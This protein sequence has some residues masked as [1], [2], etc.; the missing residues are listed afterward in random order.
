[1]DGGYHRGMKCIVLALLFF[2]TSLMAQPTITYNLEAA[3]MANLSV[4]TMND[5]GFNE[6]LGLFLAGPNA[7]DLAS[8]LPVVTVLR[9]SGTHKI[10]YLNVRYVYTFKD[11]STHA[12]YSEHARNPVM[13]DQFEPGQEIV[14]YPGVGV[15][16]HHVTGAN[17]QMLSIVAQQLLP[18]C[19]SI[20]VQIDAVTLD[21]GRLF[22]PDHSGVAQRYRSARNAV[23]DAYAES[24]GRQAREVSGDEFYSRTRKRVWEYSGG[25]SEELKRMLDL[26]APLKETIQ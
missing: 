2:A 3:H 12:G 22:G 9:N 17:A 4:L 25:R 10:G 14:L 23:A 7:P 20:E 5:L 19:D 15:I 21:N 8:I 18:K 11:G 24:I 6:A 13:G 26:F 1:M 16:G